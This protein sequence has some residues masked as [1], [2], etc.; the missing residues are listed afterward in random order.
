MWKGHSLWLWKLRGPSFLDLIETARWQV[1]TNKQLYGDTADCPR[2]TW[3]IKLLSSNYQRTT[4]LNKSNA[5]QIL[6]KQFYVDNWG[7]EAN[8]CKSRFITI[9]ILCI[10]II[11]YYQYFILV[12]YLFCSSCCFRNFGRFMTDWLDW[13]LLWER[14]RGE[15]MEKLQQ[16]EREQVINS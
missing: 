16:G 6:H 14:S 8:L 5:K 3:L 11:T 10:N 4:L 9:F 12:I 1:G 2:L 13:I 15:K 7:L